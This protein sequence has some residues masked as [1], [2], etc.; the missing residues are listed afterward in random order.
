MRT[1]GGAIETMRST[2]SIW[3]GLDRSGRAVVAVALPPTVRMNSA[4][5]PL[6]EGGPSADWRPSGTGVDCSW[7]RSDSAMAQSQQRF[8][9]C[10]H[11]L[12]VLRAPLHSLLYSASSTART[13]CAGG[14]VLNGAAFARASCFPRRQQPEHRARLG[15]CLTSRSSCFN[16]EAS[17]YQ[18]G[19]R[20]G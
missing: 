14:K 15:P 7:R 19:A 13:P 20:T 1:N 17:T 16:T 10:R 3:R 18:N 5:R 4:A 9:Q 12:A 8:N 6:L 2:S 11:W